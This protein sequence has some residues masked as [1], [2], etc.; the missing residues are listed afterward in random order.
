MRC[1][2]G[3]AGCLAALLL[4][5]FAAACGDGAESAP[6]EPAPAL[7]RLFRVDDL[8]R[9]RSVAW[10]SLRGRWLVTAGGRR[11]DGEAAGRVAAVGAAGAS[12]DRRAYGSREGAVRLETPRGIDVRGDRA[13]VVDGRRLVAVDLPDRE[14]AFDLRI[15][16]RGPLHDVAV[17]GRGII[18]VSD[19]GADAVFRV[20]PD[21]SGWTRMVTA[22][23]LR[24][25]SGLLVDRA[26]GRSGRLLAAGREGA[27]V[28]LNPDSS[29]A[30]LAEAPSYGDLDGLQRSPTGALVVAEPSTGRLLLLR[31]P[32]EESL[33]RPGVVWLDG[34][35][36]PADFVLREGV[37]AL[38]ET[39][40][41]RVSFYRVGE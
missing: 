40:A 37:L 17:D 8:A 29:V 5:A 26:P 33:W 16:G 34:L 22:G 13:Y 10:D 35:D 36:R 31:R 9:P 7:E 2:R 24:G 11:S 14:L 18:Y 28:A 12:V 27:V 25:P 19:P 38:P 23:S 41:D 32:G 30:L 3:A 4:G 15:P 21:G 1:L 20:A 6:P 39:G